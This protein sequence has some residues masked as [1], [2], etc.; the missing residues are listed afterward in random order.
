MQRLSDFISMGGYAA[1]VWPAY[2]LTIVVMAGLVAQS[3]RRY[4]RNQRALDALQRDRPRRNAP[5]AA[6]S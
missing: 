4:R 1:F 5:G 2:G 6:G 3:L